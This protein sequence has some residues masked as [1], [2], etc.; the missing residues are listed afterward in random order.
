MF[1]IYQNVDI[2][3]I[4]VDRINAS[5]YRILSTKFDYGFFDREYEQFIKNRKSEIKSR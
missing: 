3:K 1:I 2:G 5:V 4:H